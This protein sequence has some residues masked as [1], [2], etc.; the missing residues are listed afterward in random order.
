M[1]NVEKPPSF[2]LAALK[3]TIRLDLPVRSA[4][5]EVFGTPEYDGGVPGPTD[6]QT[7]IAELVLTDEN[8]KE[9]VK[10]P[11]AGEVFIA[12]ESSRGWLSPKFKQMMNQSKNSTEDMGRVHGCFRYDSLIVASGRAVDGFVCVST[13]R[14]LL[15]L[16][17]DRR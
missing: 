7:L 17:L 12:P 6:L 13:N 8:F 3:A 14:A 11:R 15:Y 5:W 16:T 9:K 4:S 2:D 10:L 1:S